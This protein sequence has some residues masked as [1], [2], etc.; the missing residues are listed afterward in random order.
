MTSDAVLDKVHEAFRQPAPGELAQSPPAPSPPEDVGPPR[1]DPTGHGPD[2]EAHDQNR[3]AVP[4]LEQLQDA[5]NDLV[6][7]SWPVVAGV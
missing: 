7:S 6:R 5:L 1:R 2:T 3:R 4:A